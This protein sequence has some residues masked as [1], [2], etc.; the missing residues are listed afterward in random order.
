M[1]R[2]AEEWALIAL[3]AAVG[4][5]LWASA[6]EPGAVGSQSAHEP[7][8]A[9]E[10]LEHEHGPRH[11]GHF[12]DADDIF[13][14]EVLLNDRG[15]LVLYVN[16][17]LNRP[18]DARG[19]QGRWRL[20]PDEPSGPSGTFAPSSDGAYLISDLPSTTSDP[21]HIEIAVRNG[22]MW[23]RMEFFL[24]LPDAGA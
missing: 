23:V 20:N 16:D 7:G 17:D 18:L 1:S 10:R 12:G 8:D 2:L 9:Q 24:P 19:L 5:P 11:G 22:A 15:Q 21:L 3:C 13:H 14:Y 4:W 6:Q